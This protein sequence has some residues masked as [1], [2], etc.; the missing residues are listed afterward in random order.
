MGQQRAGGQHRKQQARDRPLISGEGGAALS[1]RDFGETVADL[2]DPARYHY[3]FAPRYREYVGRVAALPMDSHMLLASIAPRPMLLVNGDTDTWS[4]AR[5][6]VLAAEAAR[7]VYALFGKP[8][9]LAVVTHKGGHA[10]LPE[11]LGAMAEF[12]TRHFGDRR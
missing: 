11:D 12:M 6:E 2:T 3:Q 7:P 9:D 5:G 4:D 8:N 1:R 10:V